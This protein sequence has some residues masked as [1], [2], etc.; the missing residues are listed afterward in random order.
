MPEAY[1]KQFF[2]FRQE[3]FLEFV[4]AENICSVTRREN[5]TANVRTPDRSY[6][7]GMPSKIPFAHGKANWHRFTGPLLKDLVRFFRGDVA[8]HESLPSEV[9]V[10]VVGSGDG[11][12]DNNPPNALGGQKRRT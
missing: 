8:G 5:P 3:N 1:S 12:V 6:P 2:I 4:N 10:E 7:M 11:G 9:P